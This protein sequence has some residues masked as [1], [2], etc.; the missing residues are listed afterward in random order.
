MSN[1]FIVGMPASG[2]TTFGNKLA[3]EL[4]YDFIDLDLYI[5]TNEGKSISDIFN[6]IDEER[7]R[8]LERFYLTKLKIK[9][10]TVIS[11]GGGTAAYKDNMEWMNKHGITIYLKVNFETLLQRNCTNK[12]SRPLFAGSS[13]KEIEDKMYFLLE[14]REPFFS[15]AALIINNDHTIIEM[16]NT[17]NEVINSIS[18][19][20]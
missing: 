3:K 11:T 8:E 7:F 14:K 10:K 15:L 18:K 13:N 12:T 6:Q 17:D 1:I 16:Q 9:T 5:E 2:K 4:G 19:I 20:L